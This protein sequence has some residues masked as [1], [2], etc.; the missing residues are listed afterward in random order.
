M[1]LVAESL[2]GQAK[3]SSAHFN[4]HM[5]HLLSTTGFGLAHN[6][7]RQ[8]APWQCLMKLIPSGWH[9]FN[10]FFLVRT[11]R[12][13]RR[14]WGW[15][16]REP[17]LLTQSGGCLQPSG[18]GWSLRWWL[19]C[20]LPADQRVAQSEGR[21]EMLLFQRNFLDAC[22]FVNANSFQFQF[23]KNK[24]WRRS[25]LCFPHSYSKEVKWGGQRSVL[26]E[27]MTG[28]GH[29]CCTGSLQESEYKQ[30]A[31][32][33]PHHTQPYLWSAVWQRLQ[34]E[35]P[36]E[37]LY[38]VTEGRTDGREHQAVFY[39]VHIERSVVLCRKHS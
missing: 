4:R 12:R 35:R 11:W 1:Y 29:V 28:A 17:R 7:G 19:W 14:G 9:F 23:W 2:A 5:A 34:S 30:L 21:Q 6:P 3:L 20:R 16:S 18:P 26:T 37:Q 10:A 13:P 31:W 22:L 33:P 36:T 39:C 32:A 25:Y 8:T 38:R 15:Q 24:W 27:W